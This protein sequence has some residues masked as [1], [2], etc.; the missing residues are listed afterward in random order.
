[1]LHALA[2]ADRRD[3]LCRLL[4]RETSTL[5]VRWIPV[6]RR[7]L[8]RRTVEVDTAFGRVSVKQ[9]FDDGAL[10][11]SKPEFEDCRRL[12]SASGAPLRDVIAAAERAAAGL[13]K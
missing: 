6:A 7:E 1:V 12:S 9:A 4:L 11:K 2:P 8:E 3:D 10:V 13:K 5:G